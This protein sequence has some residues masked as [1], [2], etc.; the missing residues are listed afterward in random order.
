MPRLTSAE[1]E[2]FLAEPGILCRIAT[3]NAD[4][5]PSVTPIWFIHEGG[6]ILVT[7][8]AESAWLANL[9]R[10][11]RVALSIDEQ[12]HPYRK[13]TVEGVARFVH[14]TGNDD[15]WRDL[16]RRIA[17]RYTSAEGAEHYIQETIDQPRALIAIPLAGS[18]VLTWRMP[19]PGE[20]FRGI[21]HDRYYVP[22]SKMARD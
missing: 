6:E 11:P 22:G 21:W 1:R 19:V 20:A 4:G 7:P 2:A 13:V 10:D 3:L 17:R 9:R 16:Y 18:K 8:R 15:A 14:E 5:S 12:P